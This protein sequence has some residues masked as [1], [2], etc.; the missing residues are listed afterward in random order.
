M[1]DSLLGD[2]FNISGFGVAI[3]AAICISIFNMI[4]EKAIVE[5]LYEKEK[6]TKRKTFHYSYEMFFIY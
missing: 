1:A 3:V 4:I 2:A 6:V 5:P